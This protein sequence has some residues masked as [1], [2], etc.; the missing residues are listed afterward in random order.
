V[1][2]RQPVREELPKRNLSEGGRILKK[3]AI[4]GSGLSGLLCGN[5]LAKKGHSVTIFESHVRPGGY[6]AGFWREGFYFES[7]T[8][9][10]ES[11]P[12]VNKAMEDVGLK[13]KVEF[14]R[15]RIRFVGREY[16]YI[17]EGYED[18]KQVYLN[19]FVADRAKLER[20]FGDLDEIVN[21]V[22]F[23]AKPM[24]AM[25]EGAEHTAAMQE[26]MASGMKFMEVLRKVGNVTL[27]E[28]VGRYFEEGSRLFSLLVSGA[29]PDQAAWMMAASF[30][31]F[32]EDY[33]TVKKGMQF[34][35]DTLAARFKELGGELKL[36]SPVEEIVTK[37][38]QAEGVVSKGKLFPADCV[39][40]CGDYKKTML[41]LL[42]DKALI[43]AET[44]ERIENAAVSEAFFVVYLGLDM[45]NNELQKFMK[46]PLVLYRPEA[47]GVDFYETKNEAYFAKVGCQLYSP[48]LMN[49]ELAP[50]GKSSLMIETLSPTGWMDEWGGGNRE[51]YKRLKSLAATG[52]I[53]TASRLIPNL[54]EKIVVKD[55]ATPLTFERYTHNTKGASSAWSWNPHKRFY[56]DMRSRG[57]ITP[58]KNLFIGSCWSTQFGGIPGA[59]SGAYEAMKQ[60]AD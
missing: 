32:L 2:R 14:V 17:P 5:L 46:I 40:S 52:M 3:V 26:M 49:P 6:T 58:V 4:I 8:L 50:D 37:E 11:T 35:A 51:E 9:S 36:R 48:S 22:P 12:S 23:A 10:L 15:Q 54:K 7:G 43:P 45:P 16:D 60:V 56:P 28:F 27:S 29:Y 47:P 21:A 55:A 38:G 25:Y 13:D 59:I 24:P 34:W 39:I 44:R 42:D 19:T 57:T 18:V 33:W 31:S 1:K 20:F 41:D 30:K 53:E